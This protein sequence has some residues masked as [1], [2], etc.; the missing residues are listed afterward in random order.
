MG[1]EVGQ[2]QYSEPVPSGNL[3]SLS[4]KRAKL[5]AWH[6]QHPGFNRLYKKADKLADKTN[7]KLRAYN[8]T[9]ERLCKR[10]ASAGP[11]T[12]NL[13]IAASLERICNLI[14][15]TE[16]RIPSQVR[17]RNHLANRI[18]EW[19]NLPLLDAEISQARAGRPRR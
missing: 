13:P 14:S 15:D 6:R 16:L 8:L 9:K 12:S 2:R 7:A 1:F 4:G 10:I 19:E 5:I 11:G 18:Y 3:R 17:A